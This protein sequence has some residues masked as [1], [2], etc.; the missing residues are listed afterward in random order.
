MACVREAHPDA[1][2]WVTATIDSEESKELAQ[3][4]SL[5]DHRLWYRDLSG[6][7]DNSAGEVNVPLEVRALMLDPS[8]PTKV[9][10]E[11]KT[12]TLTVPQASGAAVYDLDGNMTSLHNSWNYQ[13]QVDAEWRREGSADIDH[14]QRD[15]QGGAGGQPSRQ[16]RLVQ[17][18]SATP[19]L[20]IRY[21]YDYRWRRARKQVWYADGSGNY[22]T[23]P[24]YTIVFVYS[25]W[26]L[27]AEAEG[28][29][30]TDG[31]FTH[32][33]WLRTYYWG[34]DLSGTMEGAGGVGGLLA[35]KILAYDADPDAEGLYFAAYDGNGN[36]TGWVDADAPENWAVFDYEPFG[37]R[38]NAGTSTGTGNH[39]ATI[40]NADFIPFGFS[41][42]YT[43]PEPELAASPL[44]YYGYRYYQPALG[45]WMSRDPIGVRGGYNL[46]AFCS[47]S[48]ADTIDV[49]G[50]DVYIEPGFPRYNTYNKDLRGYDNYG[51]NFS[52]N[53]DGTGD[54]EPGGYEKMRLMIVAV[55]PTKLN[56][57]VP[58]IITSGPGATTIASPPWDAIAE[59]NKRYP[60][61]HVYL[62]GAVG[63]RSGQRDIA[64]DKIE[65][66][67]NNSKGVLWTRLK[68]SSQA[69]YNISSEARTGGRHGFVF[70]SFAD[71]DN[72]L[73]PNRL[74]LQAWGAYAWQADVVFTWAGRP[75]AG[76]IADLPIETDF[77]NKWRVHASN[78]SEHFKV[79]DIYGRRVNSEYPS[80][81]EALSR[82]II[83]ISDSNEFEIMFNVCGDGCKS[84]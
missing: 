55:D 81:P 84:K 15:P 4:S 16:N 83:G 56:D 24:D 25:G 80:D 74:T 11:E 47:N 34:Q 75:A 65:V 68:G 52:G 12:A 59:A 19:N 43:E 54:R 17:V 7:I 9:L 2:V 20:R 18:E 32:G 58:R 77:H 22:A 31:T 38:I 66:T 40:A 72:G 61:L 48:P 13:C 71:R 3:R 69:D 37:T 5:G 36:I 41:T 70:G 8:D 51:I 1:Q 67:C 76:P 29:N 64:Y 28:I 50:L 35:A 39:G 26:N 14:A 44:V 21:D 42:K 49:L 73:Y 6:Q 57:Y 82:D 60:V 63:S 23:S 78:R 30:N 46:F 62:V 33:R 27:L 45:K 10:K 79:G 53:Y